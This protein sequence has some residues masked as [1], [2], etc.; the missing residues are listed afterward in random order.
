MK[1]FFY[2]LTVFIILIILGELV[3]GYWFT[4]NNFGFYMKD[5]RDKNWKTSSTFNDKKYNFFYKRNF[6]GFRGNEFDPQNVKIIF[7]GGS[8][9]NQRYTP[10]NLTIVGQLNN[11]FIA[12]NIDVKIYNASTDGK[13]LRGIIYDFE[14]W[15]P[16]IKNLNPKY[17]ILYLGIND[18]TLA[19][20]NDV[21]QY[22]LKMKKKKTR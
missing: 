16:K 20:D 12:E 15:F 22:D 19:S 4:K 6:Y 18:Q 10:E 9:G 2:N 17:L 5:E 8:T 21:Y 1:T 3:F 11:K 13:S 7:E 14:H